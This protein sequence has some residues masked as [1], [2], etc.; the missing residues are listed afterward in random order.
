MSEKIKF[1]LHIKR[2]T[3]EGYAAKKWQRN[4]K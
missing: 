4:E 2:Q 1:R 3:P